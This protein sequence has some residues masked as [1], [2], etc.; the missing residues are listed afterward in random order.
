MNPRFSER[1]NVDAKR[2][3]GT[4]REKGRVASGSLKYFPHKAY[5]VSKIFATIRISLQDFN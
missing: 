1:V 5:E 2:T 3:D 4:D